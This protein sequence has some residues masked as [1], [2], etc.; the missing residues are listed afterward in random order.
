MLSHADEPRSRAHRRSH[1]RARARAIFEAASAPQEVESGTGDLFLFE[2]G[3][4]AR[5]EIGGLEVRVLEVRDLE[6]AGLGGQEPK[7]QGCMG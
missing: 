7:G 4:D 6:V 2:K 5:T 3:Q 1:E